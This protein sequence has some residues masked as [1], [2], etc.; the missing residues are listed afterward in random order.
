[1]SAFHSRMSADD[2][3]A[4][5]QR[6]LQLA[7]VDVEH[8]RCRAEDLR[9]GRDFRRPPLGQRAAGH[10][11]VADVAVGHRAEQHMMPLLGPLGP[12]AAGFVFGVVGMG[13]E[14]DDVESARRWA[15]RG[16]TGEGRRADGQRQSE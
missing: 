8:L 6:R 10:L 11:P 13:A 1:M 2:L 7:V 16:R 9:A 12:A 5:L 4:V 15:G 14:H 3:L